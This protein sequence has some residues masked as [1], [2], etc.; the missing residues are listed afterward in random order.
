MKTGHLVLFW[1]LAQSTGCSE[2]GRLIRLAVSP[3]YHLHDEGCLSGSYIIDTV[4]ASWNS[5][6]RSSSSVVRPLH[7]V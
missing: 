3:I 7:H 4:H 6:G 5:S 2:A 1:Q